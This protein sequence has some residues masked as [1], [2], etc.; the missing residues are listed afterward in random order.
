M[1]ALPNRWIVE[2]ECRYPAEDAPLIQPFMVGDATNGLTLGILE[3]TGDSATL[4]RREGLALALSSPNVRYGDLDGHF[5]L[6]N[7]PTIPS[8]T[9]ENGWLI[10]SESPGLGCKV[11]L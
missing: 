1:N 2:D 9:F 3:A 7:D 6:E 10:A 11:N 5:D 4:I 8:F